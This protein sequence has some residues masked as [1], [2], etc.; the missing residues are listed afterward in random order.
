MSSSKGRV[1]IM[2]ARLKSRFNNVS[3]NLLGLP[4]AKYPA[5]AH[6]PSLLFLA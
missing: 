2:L 3:D 5:T 1:I 6:D 4:Q